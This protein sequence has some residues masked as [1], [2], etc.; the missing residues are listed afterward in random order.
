TRTYARLSMN[1]MTAR[2]IRTLIS[3]IRSP[4][5][6]APSWK[7]LK[8]FKTA[9]ITR[10]IVSF[11]CHLSVQPIIS[12][13]TEMEITMLKLLTIINKEHNRLV[14]SHPG[15]DLLQLTDWAQSKRLTGWYSRRIAVGDETG[16]ILGTAML[17]FK[18]VP[19]PGSTLCYISRGFVCDFNN[20]P[21]VEF[22]LKEALKITEDENAD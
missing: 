15:C 9:R 11:I 1:V 18:K 14:E 16:K 12:D 10:I 21:L 8:M 13:I 2:I 7:M 4:L 20:R 22:M 17:L 19:K 3:A 5:E 6:Y